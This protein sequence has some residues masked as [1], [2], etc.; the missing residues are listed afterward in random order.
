MTFSLLNVTRDPIP[1]GNDVN[2]QKGK[3]LGWSMAHTLYT[4]TQE[5]VDRQEGRTDR[6]KLSIGFINTHSLAHIQRQ[7]RALIKTA[8]LVFRWDLARYIIY[9]N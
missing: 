7:I 3:T 8:T 6:N 5:T 1:P 2:R 9:H 4:Q